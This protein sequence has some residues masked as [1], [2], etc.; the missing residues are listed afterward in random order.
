MK[1]KYAW[2][3]GDKIFVRTVTYHYVGKLVDESDHSFWLE[4]ASWV[5]DSGRFHNALETGTLSEVEPY[6]GDGIVEIMKTGIIDICEW[7]HNLP[8]EVA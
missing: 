8:E 5:A 1:K 2:E 6:P 7:K 4:N 3:I